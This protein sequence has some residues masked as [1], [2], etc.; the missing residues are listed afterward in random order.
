MFQPKEE[1]VRG[2]QLEYEL[3]AQARRHSAEQTS[4]K[5]RISDLELQLIE[6]RKEADEY[7]RAN[8]ERNMEVTTLNNQVNIEIFFYFT[9]SDTLSLSGCIHVMC[10]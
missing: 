9:A 7:H 5:Q 10:L 1:K 8:I 3:S 6:A 2:D 4:L